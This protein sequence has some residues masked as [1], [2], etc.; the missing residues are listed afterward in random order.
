[1]SRRNGF[2]AG[3]PVAFLSIVVPAPGPDLTRTP[4]PGVK[5][6]YRWTGI[7]FL[8][9]SWAPFLIFMRAWEAAGG[10]DTA[11]LLPIWLYPLA[12]AF[13]PLL[14]L[15]ALFAI[16]SSS[17]DILL[18]NLPILLPIALTM[19]LSLIGFTLMTLAKRRSPLARLPRRL[20]PLRPL[21]EGSRV[22]RVRVPDRIVAGI[23]PGVAL[24]DFARAFHNGET[25][26]GLTAAWPA[27]L[28]AWFYGHGLHEEGEIEL[29][30]KI[31]PSP[32]P[33]EPHRA[34]ESDRARWTAKT[35]FGFG[36]LLILASVPLGFLSAGWFSG[37][38]DLGG[39]TAWYEI[40]AL[41]MVPALPLGGLLYILVRLDRLDEL[42]FLLFGVFLLAPS[43]VSLLGFALI[44]RA[45]GRPVWIAL[46]GVFGLLIPRR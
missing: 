11:G 5:A 31:V 24:A 16:P 13:L 39:P 18:Q 32:A 15:L 9:A 36:T 40:L 8:L 17:P 19:I 41:T 34:P 7:A 26:E 33:A 45:K 25:R 4:A 3:E 2:D 42:A 6:V 44:A 14:S 35:L 23:A 22:R 20:R 43:F 46:L 21:A 10:G 37:I 1:M 29:L 12:W 38:E 28:V 27:D 30:P